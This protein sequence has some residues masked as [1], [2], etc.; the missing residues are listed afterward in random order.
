[1]AG[2][3]LDPARRTWHLPHS[4]GGWLTPG[5][6]IVRRALIPAGIG[7]GRLS[8]RMGRRRRARLASMRPR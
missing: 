2:V 7:L 6:P 5:S 3:T 4:Y 8:Y 1:M